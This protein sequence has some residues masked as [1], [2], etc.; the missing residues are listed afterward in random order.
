MKIKK[1]IIFIICIGFLVIIPN[2]LISLYS[3][4]FEGTPKSYSTIEDFEK[5]TGVKVYEFYD[6]V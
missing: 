6:I 3:N 4:S 5:E 2:W 1:I